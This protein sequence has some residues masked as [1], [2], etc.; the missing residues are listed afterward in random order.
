MD[1]GAVK[2]LLRSLA[3]FEGLGGLEFRVPP[4]FCRCFSSAT[5]GFD[6]ENL[7]ATQA[8]PQPFRSQMIHWMCSLAPAELS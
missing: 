4:D 5:I 6:S 2:R 3:A 7:A 1:V 8:D